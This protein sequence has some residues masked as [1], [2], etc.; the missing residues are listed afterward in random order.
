MK[1]INSKFTF[2]LKKIFPVFWVMILFSM[3]VVILIHNQ[4]IE[5]LFIGI[6]VTLFMLV[7]GLLVY[8]F[9]LSNLMDE[10]Y[11]DGENLVFR[12]SGEQI[13]L[14]LT[15]I[16]DYKYQRHMNPHNVTINT[17]HH[18]KFGKKLVFLAPTTYVPF[19]KNEVIMQLLEKL[20]KEPKEN[21]QKH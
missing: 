7:I 11:L 10:V 8:K 17:K 20:N 1:R 19:R 4:K 14:F 6:F 5:T 16:K 18:T 2:L 9:L 15:D 3:F 13:K 21:H 12:N